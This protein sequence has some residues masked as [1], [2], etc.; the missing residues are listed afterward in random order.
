MRIPL[1]MNAKNDHIEVFY[2][3]K[4]ERVEFPFK[5]LILCRAN[6]MP[7]ISSDIT[8]DWTLVPYQKT[9]KFNKFTFNT[10]KSYAEFKEKYNYN[11]KYFYANSYME[12]LFISKPDFACKFANSNPI[13]IMFYDIEVA[14]D[15]RKDFPTADDI[16]I[17]CIGYSFWEYHDGKYKFL[18]KRILDT[19]TEEILDTEILNSFCEDVYNED[20]DILLGFNCNRF[21]FPYIYQRCKIQSVDMT[22]LTRSGKEPWI[23]DKG[24]IYIN[25]RIHYDAYLKVK[26]DQSLMGFKRKTLKVIARHYKV[27][28]SAELDIELDDDIKN[29][30]K[31]WKE[32]HERLITYQDAD[33]VRTETVGFVYIRNDIALAEKLGVP[34]ETTMNTYSSF[35]PK[36]FF[37]RNM[38]DKRMISTES[39]FD[40]YNSQTGS[41]Y[42][43]PKDR[44]KNKELRFQGA[45]VG[46]YKHGKVNYC[47]KL[48]FASMY[49]SAICT[50]NLGPDTTTLIRVDAY[51][52]KYKFSEDDKYK[53]YSIPDD[54]FGVDLVVRVRKDIESFLKKEIKLLWSERKD[55]KKFMKDDPDRFDMY[56]SQQMAVKVINNSVYGMLGL[57]TS[58]YGDM[59]SGIMV[60]AMCRWCTTNVI[61]NYKDVLVELDTDGLALDELVD[62]DETNKFLDNIIHEKFDITENY[63]QMELEDVGPAYFCAMKNYVTIHDGKIQLHG[64]TLKSS[65]NAKVVDRAIE[66]AIQHIFYGKPI[67]EVIREAYDYSS[68]SMA[69]FEERVRLSKDIEEYSDIT[70]QVP[71]LTKQL[72]IATGQPV[73]EDTQLTYVCT[74]SA[75]IGKEFEDFYKNKGPKKTNYTIIELC[76]GF[77]DLDTKY[78]DS[79]ITTKLELFDIQRI[80]KIDLFSG[81]S[82]EQV[83]HKLDII[84]PYPGP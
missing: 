56:N 38:W 30:K 78:Y 49:P 65:R 46:L 20:P 76:K 79:L 64:S 17:I 52:G 59:I 61:N 33:I 31:V 50:F 60:T 7:E 63:M 8:E 25:G 83:K 3:G 29:V 39:N 9:I 66:L 27:P 36:L 57:K 62:A 4:Q 22:R 21:D 54:N 68:L 37:A 13:K 26:K 45:M 41:V 24:D 15:G 5:P 6:D 43:F 53:W 2:N 14:T 48:D 12:Q 67:E 58:T 47:Y 75:V 72:E 10:I 44:Y 51:T 32:N 16:P 1:I 73:E 77:K 34:L 42:K 55:L 35:I 69:D 70:G 18:S 74:K 71:F 40:K 28:L 81:T 23:T 19:Y 11:S 84:P 82:Y 80:E